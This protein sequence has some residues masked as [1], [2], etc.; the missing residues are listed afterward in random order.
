MTLPPERRLLADYVQTARRLRTSFEEICRAI[1]PLMPV[2]PEVVDSDAGHSGLFIAAFLKRF[3]QY[4]DC[5]HRTLRTIA[6]VMAL[7]ADERLTAIDVA[8]KA[9]AFG[10]V[11]EAK[12]SEAV[13]TRNALAHE[14]PLDAAKRAGQVN[15]SWAARETLELTWQGI[16]RFL[17]EERLLED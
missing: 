4:E 14:Y 13:R 7:G 16:E 5:L 8:R 3:E 15:R 11:A 17:S 9:E 2:A 6:R 1:E 12:W 10:I